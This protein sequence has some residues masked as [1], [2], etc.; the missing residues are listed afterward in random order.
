MD[1]N[2]I[3]D[4]YEVERCADGNIMFATGHVDGEKFTA[5]ENSVDG[6]EVSPQHLYEAV[7]EARLSLAI[8]FSPA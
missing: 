5:T 3:F 4:T 7:A 2:V 8:G 1:K 6:L